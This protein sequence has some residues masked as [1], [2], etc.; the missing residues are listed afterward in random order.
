MSVGS[1]VCPPLLHRQELEKTLLA[2]DLVRRF[3]T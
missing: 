1:F 3:E 2:D